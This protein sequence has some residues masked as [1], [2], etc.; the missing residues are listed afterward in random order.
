LPLSPTST[1]DPAIGMMADAALDP[2]SRCRGSLG[3]SCVFSSILS[4]AQ[5]FA[6]NT[7]WVGSVLLVLELL[8][9]ASRYGL[10]SRLRG[11]FFWLANI[12]IAATALTLFSRGFASLGVHPLFTFRPYA[13]L[14]TGI[15]LLRPAELIVS[16]ILG[17][18]VVMF[19]YYWF[20]R[21]QHANRWL[22]RFHRVHHSLREMSAL[23]SNHHFTEEIFK[24]P[25]VLLP[26]SLLVG[27]DA[28]PTPWII[29]TIFSMQSLF[30][31]S[32]TRLNLGKLRYIVNDNRFHRIHHSIEPAHRDKNFCS[33]TPIWDMV[34]GTAHFPRA[35]EW[36]ETGVEDMPEPATL[37]ELLLGP[38]RTANEA[39][40]PAVATR[41]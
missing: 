25:F 29:A 27:V 5:N 39:A 13:Y 36:P 2:S 31:H 24:I 38:F 30:E 37:R 41:L 32:C 16:L 14:E 23:N 8:L 4:F 33:F 17:N 10:Y 26:L 22:W 40:G 3:S 15:D 19:F 12:A 21:L 20:H 6:W 7:L 1:C 11:Y 28:G 18:W 34:F 9:P 35:D